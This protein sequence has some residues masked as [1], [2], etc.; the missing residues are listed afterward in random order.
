MLKE[1]MYP[2]SKVLPEQ[3]ELISSKPNPL[4]IGDHLNLT[5]ISDISNPTAQ[6]VWVSASHHQA[7]PTHILPGDFNAEYVRG[8]LM[9]T[10]RKDDDDRNVTCTVVPADT[11]IQKSY[12]LKVNCKSFFQLTH[13]LYCKHAC[14][15][16]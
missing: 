11:F 15:W 13:H 9:I 10:A 6:L 4:S 12:T 1:K 14:Y 5:C 2:G 3:I 7:A 8:I 16:Y